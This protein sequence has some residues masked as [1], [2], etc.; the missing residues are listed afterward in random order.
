MNFDRYLEEEWTFL[1]DLDLHFRSQFDAALSRGQHEDQWEVFGA[2]RMFSED[3]IELYERIECYSIFEILSEKDI[4]KTLP[5]GQ[6][7][8][9]IAS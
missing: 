1:P 4:R 5:A 8:T 2:A 7:D 3:E 6:R 9:Q